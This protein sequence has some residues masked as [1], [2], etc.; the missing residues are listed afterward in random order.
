VV[1][2]FAAPDPGKDEGLLALAIFGYQ[3]HDRLPDHLFLA[4]TEQAF[5]AFVP[6]LDNSVIFLLTIASSEDSTIA[7]S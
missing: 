7:A 4:I 2:G 5:C 6:G 3:Q 1:N